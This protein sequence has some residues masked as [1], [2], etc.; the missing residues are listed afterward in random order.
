MSK[1]I[2]LRVNIRSVAEYVRINV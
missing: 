2:D 1:K